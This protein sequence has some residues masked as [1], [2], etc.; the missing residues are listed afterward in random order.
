MRLTGPLGHLITERCIGNYSQFYAF[1]A[2]QVG[3]IPEAHGANMRARETNHKTPS[4][5]N[6]HYSNMH[7]TSGQS[8][9]YPLLVASECNHTPL[10]NANAPFSEENTV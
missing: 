9:W 8:S 7:V 10:S 1:Q 5:A 6:T 4:N 2:S 3:L